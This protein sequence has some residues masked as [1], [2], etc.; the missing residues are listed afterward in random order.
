MPPSYSRANMGQEGRV[1]H[2]SLPHRVMEEHT[3]ESKEL[4]AYLPL[5]AIDVDDA[6][7]AVHGQR[8][9]GPRRHAH[10]GHQAHADPKPRPR[11]RL[12]LEAPQS[13]P[14]PSKRHVSAVVLVVYG[15]RGRRGD[16]DLVLLPLLAPTS[17]LALRQEVAQHAS[18]QHHQG[19][20]PEQEQ[21]G[22]HT[23][24]P[25]HAEEDVILSARTPD[26]EAAS[27][28]VRR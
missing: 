11:T 4:A 2:V 20:E 17:G 3:I 8:A 10:D 15:Q 23:P 18:G 25:H 12:D 26:G 19:E 28:V 7:L 1:R 24:T 22:A 27:R 6:R 16:R 13:L 5:P 21:E 9:A 14:A